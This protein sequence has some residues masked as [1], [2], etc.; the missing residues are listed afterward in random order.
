MGIEKDAA[1]D[2]KKSALLLIAGGIIV[3]TGAYLGYGYL[4][5][6][7]AT[8]SQYNI[9]RVANNASVNSPE[10]AQYRQLQKEANQI[11][12]KA[13]DND[14]HSFVASLRM[15][16]A[17]PDA[18]MPAAQSVSLNTTP[19]QISQAGDG[20]TNGIPEDQKA[21]LKSYLKILNDRWKP[22]EVQ[23]AG[24]FTQ[25]GQGQGGSGQNSAPSGNAFSHWTEGLPGNT[26][27]TRVSSGHNSKPAQDSVVVPPNTRR[28]A[29]IDSAVDSDNLNSIVLAHIPAGFLSGASFSAQGV[30][31]A[32]NGVVI[33]LTRMTLNG[34]E[35]QVDAYALQDDTLQ[36]SV[37][38][39]VNNRYFTRI[40]LPAVA[41]G[42]GGV[43]DLYKQQNTQILATNAGTISGGTG[44]VKG[45]AVAGTIAGGIGSQ[46]GQVMASDAA[47]MPV[48]QVTVY[49]NQVVAI[50]FMKGVY[51]SD[52]LNKSA[53]MYSSS[54]P[55]SGEQ[56]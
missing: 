18:S 48:K 47:R 54:A 39:D 31:L 42:I 37:A 50:Q 19:T 14:G 46:A 55:V 25:G 3:A 53:E 38:S 52:L 33:H 24:T 6:P 56:Q 13:A 30:Q 22:G 32:G 45:S 2:G 10:T 21:A 1:S 9:N 36:S 34:K 15:S 26:P 51:D 5:R 16:D 27:V 17:K 4:N 29:V 43:G 20:A 49:K 7:Q 40:I 11:G 12:Q 41:A 28:P 35:Y 44:T 8:P 23:L